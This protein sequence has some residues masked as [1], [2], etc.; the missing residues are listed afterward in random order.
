ML[1]LIA[2]GP[3]KPR[4][5]AAVLCVAMV[6]GIVLEVFVVLYEARPLRWSVSLPCA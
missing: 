3:R 5:L 4:W 1:Y 6:C 2:F